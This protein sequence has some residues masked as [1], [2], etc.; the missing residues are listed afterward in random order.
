[1]AFEDQ[2]QP[3][4]SLVSTIIK[5]LIWLLVIALLVFLIIKFVVPKVK[6]LTSS[7][8]KEVV[9]S[10]EPVIPTPLATSTPTPTPKPTATVKP[11]AT[12]RVATRQ[13]DS[14]PT[15]GPETPLLA[16]VGGLSVSGAGLY[17]ARLKRSYKNAAR[18]I[19]VLSKPE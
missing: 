19:S 13:D 3:K 5:A 10:F 8:K 6:S 7:N 14:L 17:V 12:P 15:T 11:T 18:H 1:M 9:A 4:P 2:L 16:L